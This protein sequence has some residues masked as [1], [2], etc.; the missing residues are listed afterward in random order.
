M[1]IPP[2]RAA[3]RRAPLA[4]LLAVGLVVGAASLVSA[5]AWAAVGCQLNDPQRDIQRLFPE[6]K[7]FVT[8]Q[9]TFQ[10]QGPA[11][12][13]ALGERLGDA[14]DPLWETADVPYSRYDVYGEAGL[15]GWVIG[16]NQRGTYSNIQLHVA[17]N[18]DGGTRSVYLQSIR[19]PAYAKFQS[20]DLLAALAKVPL[21]TYPRWSA[22]YVGGRCEGFPVVDP[23]GGAEAEDY[24]HILRALAK[25]ELLRELL[26]R[27]GAV[28]VPP[29]PR[30]QA[31]WIAD[32]WPHTP[33]P[34]YPSPATFVAADRAPFLEDADPV[35]VWLS[36]EGP[37]AW[38]VWLLVGYPVVP[39]TVG[40]VG[41]AALW[42]R[43]ASTGFVV[44]GPG[45]DL[46]RLG[47]TSRVLHGVSIYM[48]VDTGSLWS[49]LTG[50]AIWGARLGAKLP[51][52]AGVSVQPWA[53]VRARMPGVLVV[54]PPSAAAPSKLR[55]LANRP[56]DA[57]RVVALADRSASW[58]LADVPRGTAT[59]IQVGKGEAVLVRGS[60]G[61]IGLEAVAG[62]G[63]LEL[64]VDGAAPGGGPLLRDTRSHATYRGAT[65]EALGGAAGGA[66]GRLAPLPLLELPEDTWRALVP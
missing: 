43:S 1:N 15:V 58:R 62:G 23:T 51:V 24:R 17:L 11:A 52:A 9:I 55:L 14:L 42:S 38:P 22:C 37:R 36:P 27:P 66:G 19:S 60:G 46:P 63:G 4:V 57:H 16:A 25:L 50:S 49:P 10:L 3:H 61:V 28:T 12:Y 32:V 41:Y 59:P 26:L 7:W 5:P 39:I 48:D 64:V 33:A 18:A 54:E 20:P 65:G 2:K 44:G 45:A 53:E 8:Q 21:A 29:S 47:G 13:A 6:M 34:R 35:L 56:P 30:A 40:G 31:E